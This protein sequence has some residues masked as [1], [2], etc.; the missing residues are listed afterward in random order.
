MTNNKFNVI[1]KSNNQTS[2]SDADR[3]V[4]NPRVNG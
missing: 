2:V 1:G 4:P 3:E